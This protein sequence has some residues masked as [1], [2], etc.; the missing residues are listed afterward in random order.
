MTRPMLS[1]EV[2]LGV[3]LAGASSMTVGCSRGAAPSPDPASAP[4][5]AAEPAP[6]PAT[7]TAAP[8]ASKENEVTPVVAV[9]A[10]KDVPAPNAQPS[11]PR[12]TKGGSA[13]C[14]AQGC[15]PEMKKGN[16]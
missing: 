9:D 6:P 15:S 4:A 13:S 11:K 10:G 5:K 2:F 16:K 12:T 14:G 1:Y 3:L 8:N 7:A